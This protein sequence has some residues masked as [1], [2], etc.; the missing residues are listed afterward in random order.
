MEPTIL[1]LFKTAVPSALGAALTGYY[2]NEPRGR[3]AS[4]GWPFLGA[5]LLSAVWAICISVYYRS[6]VDPSGMGYW[7]V[8]TFFGVIVVGLIAG[9]SAGI[10]GLQFRKERREK[11]VAGV[12]GGALLPFL[13]FLIS[14]V[15]F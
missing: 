5:T 14:Q 1:V 4:F 2:Q 13:L 8:I 6:S 9:V 7:F 12:I 11:Y 3:L 15:G 10:L